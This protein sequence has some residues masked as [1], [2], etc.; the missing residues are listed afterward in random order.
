MAGLALAS[1]PALAM[2]QDAS[3]VAKPALHVGDTWIINRTLQKGSGNFAQQRTI[4][5]V[6]RLDSD[7]MLIGTRLDGSPL[8]PQENM[9]GLDWSL[10]LL[11][12]DEEKTTAKPLNFPMHV[13]DDWISEWTDPRRSGNQ[14][15]AHFKRTYKVVGWEDVTVPAGTFHALKIESKGTAEA[16]MV[17][18]TVVGGAVAA[19]PGSA[20]TVSHAQQG[21]VGMLRITTFS[22]EYYAPEVRYFVKEVEEQYNASNVMIE[23]DTHE[24]ASFKPGA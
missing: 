6:D 3:S 20:T 13:G 24:L 10:R 12:K 14:L 9:I 21:G 15:T 2:A 11:I 18:P 16:T 8:A 1:F 22:V 17:V 4:Q 23:R 5:T 7:G 19:I